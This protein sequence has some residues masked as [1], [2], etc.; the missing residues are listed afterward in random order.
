MTLSLIQI[1][2]VYLTQSL[3]ARTEM[4]DGQSDTSSLSSDMALLYEDI[5]K[6]R[7][8]ENDRDR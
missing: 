7:G 6:G 1:P 5:F 8:F 4:T 2:V 3:L